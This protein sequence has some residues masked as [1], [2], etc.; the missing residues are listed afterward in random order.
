MYDL[1]FIDTPAITH[2]SQLLFQIMC[3]NTRNLILDSTCP[4]TVPH[5]VVTP[6]EPYLDECSV[7]WQNRL[8]PQSTRNLVVPQ[9]YPFPLAWMPPPDSHPQQMQRPHEP[10]NDTPL[11]RPKAVFSPSRFAQSVQLQP[12]D[13]KFCF[14]LTCHITQVQY[15]ANERLIMYHVTT[16]IQKHLVKALVRA[17][18]LFPPHVDRFQPHF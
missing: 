3:R 5:I 14:R 12:C 11:L 2:L 16:A 13:S 10:I 7:L 17:S 15:S 1:S 4:E 18:T 9:C 6:P 8:H